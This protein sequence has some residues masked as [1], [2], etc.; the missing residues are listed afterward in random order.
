MITTDTIALVSALIALCAAIISGIYTWVTRK[1]LLAGYYP[2]VEI[3]FSAPRFGVE[4]AQL[5]VEL[6]NLH[7][8]VTCRDVHVQVY[9]RQPHRF[10][11][12]PPRSW[13]LFGI[14]PS[15][16]IS[17]GQTKA[18]I[19]LPSEIARV[20]GTQ[21]PFRKVAGSTTEAGLD[22][23]LAHYLPNLPPPYQVQVR[24]AYRPGIPKGPR[25]RKTEYFTLFGSS[26]TPVSWR[27]MPNPKSS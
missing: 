25:L 4:N 27:T 5:Q 2:E 16:I 1:Q 3:G 13:K 15:P 19:A 22:T 8:T 24:V 11:H 26:D 21:N 23:M 17:G 12:W 7:Q 20:R 6:R 9:F 10:R 18:I 14:G